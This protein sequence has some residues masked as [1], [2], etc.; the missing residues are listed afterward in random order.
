[1]TAL[2]HIPWRNI[3][4]KQLNRVE[5]LM[6]FLQLS[7]A[8]R[9]RV[10]LKPEFPLLVPLRLAEKMAK[11]TLED[12]IV[13]QFLPLKE[14]LLTA[15]DG[16]VLDPVADAT[17]RKSPKFLQ[18]YLGRGLI[19]CTSACAMHCRYCFR[20]NFDYETDQHGFE[21]EIELISQDTSLKEVILSGGDP[22]SLSNEQLGLLISQIEKIPH[23]KRLRFHT[24]FPIGIPERIDQGF[25]E[26]LTKTS[27]QRY[28]V[29]HCN[30]VKE[31]DADILDAMKAL[32]GIGC[33]ILNQSVLL[34]D[35]ND[36]SATLIDLC[37]TLVNHSILPYYLHQLDPVSGS[38]HFQVAEERGLYLIKEISKVLPG[39][40]VP[41]YVREI[42]GSPCKTPMA[43]L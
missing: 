14:E 9:E 22:L 41:K 28:I 23:I 17:F 26:I 3:Q 5:A 19:L 25:L 43:G 40:A 13:K 16:F 2:P 39:Y 30:H 12:P 15:L 37:E 7:T 38:N 31:L 24:R 11:K 1:M 33:I 32:Q 18:K 8:Q 35:V 10:A 42:A 21:E 29:I 36:D 34:K 4:R 6:D 20:K 27:L